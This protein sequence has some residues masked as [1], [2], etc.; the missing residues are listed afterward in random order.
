MLILKNPCGL[1]KVM[2]C[3]IKKDFCMLKALFGR[4]HNHHSTHILILILKSLNIKT[5]NFALKLAFVFFRDLN[6]LDKFAVFYLFNEEVSIIIKIYIIFCFLV[7]WARGWRLLFPV[8]THQAP[9]RKSTPSSRDQF[10][11][12]RISV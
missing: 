5:I 1:N 12:V 4:V 10:R 8:A 3:R 9:S 11:R 6:G 7:L 2:S